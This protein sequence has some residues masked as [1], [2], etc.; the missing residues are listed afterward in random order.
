MMW[1]KWNQGFMSKKFDRRYRLTIE[2]GG[3]AIVIEQPLTLQ[4]NVQRN[5]MSSVNTGTFQIYNLSED[6]RNSI[7]Q[8]RFSFLEYKKVILEAG[9]DDLATVFSGSL[10][11]ANSSRQ[12]T[13]VITNVFARDGGF[14]TV[15]TK[16][17]KTIQKG[18]TYKD[19]IKNLISDF[20]NLTEGS[21][22][23]V[24]GSLLRPAVLDGNTFYLLKTYTGE[25][26]FI[27]LE[28]V[29]VLK[30]SEVLTGQVPLISPQ[31]GLLQTPKR[32]DAYLTVTTLFEPRIIMSQFVELRSDI[33]EQYNGQYKV[34]GVNHQG[35]I[36]GAIGGQCTSTFNLLLE[37]QLFGRFS[38]V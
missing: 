34:L 13:D 23:E 7:F 20:P 5:A 2:I 4:F 28:K 16:T 33:L 35:I 27:D 31:T 12:G 21:I 38:A 19:L 17:F 30:N 22:G 10:F 8:D 36:S 37:G 3:E 32:D 18:V 9:Y 11:E 6:V 24:E 1:Q 15:T 25:Q 26:I 14:D 29:N